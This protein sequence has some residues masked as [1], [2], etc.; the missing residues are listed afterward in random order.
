MLA[1]KVCHLL[2]VGDVIKASQYCCCSSEAKI[3]QSTHCRILIP[4]CTFS[5]IHLLQTERE[6]CSFISYGL[7]SVNVEGISVRHETDVVGLLILIAGSRKW[8]NGS[9]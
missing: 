4:L 7:A 3:D 5:E 9:L 1:A 6:L 2:A 8:R